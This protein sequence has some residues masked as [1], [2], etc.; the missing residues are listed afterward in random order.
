MDVYI[1]DEMKDYVY[2]DFFVLVIMVDIKNSNG[3]L[4]IN[5]DLGG[6]NY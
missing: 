2:M 6:I 1:M 4:E 3:L 5:F